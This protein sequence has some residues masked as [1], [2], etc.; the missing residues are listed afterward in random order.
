MKVYV[1]YEIKKEQFINDSGETEFR[2]LFF[3]GLA[4]RI[5]ELILNKIEIN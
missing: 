1:K 5:K 3:R 4:P 2:H